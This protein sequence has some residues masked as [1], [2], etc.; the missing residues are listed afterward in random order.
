ATY[1]MKFANILYAQIASD[2]RAADD[3]AHTLAH[4]DLVVYSW[5][6]E[7]REA[8]SC[9]PP[10]Q[11]KPRRGPASV[12]PADTTAPSTSTTP[13][14]AP[15]EACR[16]PAPGGCWSAR[17]ASATNKPTRRRRGRTSTSA[18]PRTNS[19]SASAP[20]SPCSTTRTGAPRPPAKQRERP[21]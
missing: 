4:L 10:H 12:A 20:N 5:A 18:P 9:T 21:A 8:P 16:R 2:I 3:A 15:G 1:L 6:A 19:C 14:P 7:H 11:N 13:T 17:P